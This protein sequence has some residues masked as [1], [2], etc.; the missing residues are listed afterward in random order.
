MDLK[1]ML[2]DARQREAQIAIDFDRK[3]EQYK[4]KVLENNEIR[5]QLEKEE[6]DLKSQIPREYFQESSEWGE[7]LE[8]IRV[9]ER[10][11][12]DK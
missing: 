3:T 9:L 6:K 4:A 7:V 11:V 5:R 1:Q 12:G 2:S 8:E 10:L